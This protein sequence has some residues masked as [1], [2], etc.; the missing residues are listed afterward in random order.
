MKILNSYNVLS[1]L[2]EHLPL[3]P[4]IIEAGAFNGL[5]T[6]KMAT[7]WPQGTI[8]AFEPVPE[9]FQQLVKETSDY[10]TI[11]HYPLALSNNTGSAEFFVAK[12]PKRPQAICQAG[13]LHRPTGRLKMSPITYP[14]SIAVNTI[15]LQDWANLH[16]VDS[17]DFM[18][19]DMQG[20]ELPALQASPAFVK[21]TS[22]ILL[23]VN[24][25]DA[26]ENQPSYLQIHT[27]ME[28]QGFI[29]LAKDFDD[30]PHRFFGNIIY[31]NKAS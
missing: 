12:H 3:N 28:S 29:A 15:T 7:L 6:K 4:I 21:K 27:W 20:H 23:E 9:I 24:F 5:D 14:H 1:F 22:L 26:Y 2:S 17:V 11:R 25:I 18:W 30:K 13:S 31:K 16:A 19:L 10:S 8:H